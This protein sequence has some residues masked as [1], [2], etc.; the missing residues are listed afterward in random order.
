MKKL[1]LKKLNLEA[2]NMLQRN[3]L[4][5]V[6]GGYGEGGSS[7]SC[8]WKNPEGNGSANVRC[9]ISKD[10]AKS[11]FNNWGGNWCCESCASNGGTASYC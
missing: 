3:Q 1:S 8:G 6:L 9:N 7:G 10:E 11:L 2:N 4:K 5:T